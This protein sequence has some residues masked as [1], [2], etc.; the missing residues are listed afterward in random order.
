MLAHVFWSSLWNH[1]IRS[2]FLSFV[3]L[4]LQSYIQ[5]LSYIEVKSLKQGKLWI[6]IPS[7]RRSR[8]SI[9]IIAN[10]RSLLIPVVTSLHTSTCC[11]VFNISFSRQPLSPSEIDDAKWFP[12][13]SAVVKFLNNTYKDRLVCCIPRCLRSLLCT[14]R[15]LDNTSCF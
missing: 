11:M 10:V 12:C 4:T 2:W 1:L 8:K 15:L 3:I 6:L 9:I 13:S 14:V 7:F 5:R